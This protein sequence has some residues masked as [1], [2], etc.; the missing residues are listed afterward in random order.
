M[1]ISR[2]QFELMARMLK[3]PTAYSDPK[4]GLTARERRLLSLLWNERL[5]ERLG[6][7]GFVLTPDGN[8]LAVTYRYLMGM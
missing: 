4:Y 7:G 5:V 8:A 6:G 3:D 1:A 2:R